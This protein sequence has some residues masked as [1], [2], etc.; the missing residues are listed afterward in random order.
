MLIL[1]LVKVLLNFGW[2]LAKKYKNVSL[3]NRLRICLENICSS[4]LLLSAVRLLLI[5][6]N[7]LMTLIWKMMWRLMTLMQW[8]FHNIEDNPAYFIKYYILSFLTWLAHLNIFLINA[9]NS[10][11]MKARTLSEEELSLH[12]SAL[13]Q[14]HN[15]WFQEMT[16][17]TFVNL[18]LL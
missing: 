6:S 1:G 10:L 3:T 2:T 9:S 4:Y 16:L 11:E 12:F 17:S 7:Y 18:Y 14:L 13:N 8:A 15:L 5:I